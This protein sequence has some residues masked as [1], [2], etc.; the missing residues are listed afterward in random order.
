MIPRR[1]RDVPPPPASQARDWRLPRATLVALFAPSIGDDKALAVILDAAQGLA[2]EG[3]DYDQRE[4][5]ALLEHIAATPGLVGIVA[6]FLK[7]RVPLQ[8]ATDR[9]R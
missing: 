8:W 1:A 7:A 6:R 9:L 4:A 2:I 3:T 5:L